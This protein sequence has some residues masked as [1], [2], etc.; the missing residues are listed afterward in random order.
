MPV[1]ATKR[2]AARTPLNSDC[3]VLICGASFA[4]LAVARELAGSGARVMMVDRYEVGERQTSACAA[5]TAWLEALSLGA[6]IRQTFGELVINTPLTS[7]R[8]QLPWTLSTF[9]YPELC[10]LLAEQGGDVR[11]ETAKVEGIERGS[12]AQ[13]GGRAPR[14]S[15]H[16]V[17][18]D[19]GELRAPLVVDA[20]GWRRVLGVGDHVQPPE[21]RLSRGLEVHPPGGSKDLEIWIDPTYVRAGYSW[22]FP[23]V[24]SCASASA[25][26]SHA[27]ASRSPPCGWRR[28]WAWR[29]RATRA[30]GSPTSCAPRSRAACSSPGTPPGTACR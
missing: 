3:D 9:D 22:N 20:L 16:T 1:R 30:T 27:T 7:I 24:R 5:P 12:A 17:R 2:G 18:T 15:A 23:P 13:R 26:S 10:R 25:P 19:R 21:A 6:S 28:T 11:F 4:G 8:Y 29:P 14:R